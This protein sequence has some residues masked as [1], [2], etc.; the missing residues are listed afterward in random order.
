MTYFQPDKLKIGVL[1]GG[2]LAVSALHFAVKPREANYAHAFSAL[3]A[4]L[5]ENGVQIQP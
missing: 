3:A 2:Q 4:V 5:R 1:G